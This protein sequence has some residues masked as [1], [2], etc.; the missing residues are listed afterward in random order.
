VTAGQLPKPVG[1]ELLGIARE[2]FTQAFQMTAGLSAAIAIAAAVVT[3][4]VLRDVRTGGE[5]SESR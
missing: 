2:A 5:V 3:V 1:Q 4:F